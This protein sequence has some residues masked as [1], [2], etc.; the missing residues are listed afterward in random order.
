[1]PKTIAITPSWYWPAG[2]TRVVGVPPF[3][4]GEQL[5]DRFLRNLDA[6]ERLRRGCGRAGE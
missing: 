5:V 3:R 4:I 6:V 1:M 2:V